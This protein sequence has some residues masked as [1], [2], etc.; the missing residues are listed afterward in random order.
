ML[1]SLCAVSVEHRYKSVVIRPW[2]M[3]TASPKTLRLLPTPSHD[4]LQDAKIGGS[5]S[6]EDVSLPLLFATTSL[7]HIVVVLEGHDSPVQ[8]STPEQSIAE[9]I[10]AIAS[11]QGSTTWHTFLEHTC[12]EARMDHCHSAADAGLVCEIQ[13]KAA[14]EISF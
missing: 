7:L 10:F 3:L 2:S 1:F 12:S 5:L 4:R 9:A 14:A 11:S 6:M 13:V 8:L